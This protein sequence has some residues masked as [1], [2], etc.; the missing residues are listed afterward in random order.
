MGRHRDPHQ[1]GCSWPRQRAPASQS[2]DR[3]QT[4]FEA[5]PELR[6]VKVSADQNQ[7]VL[8]APDPLALVEG[9]P[10][11]DKVKY[12]SRITLGDPQNTFAAKDPD[13]TVLI[14]ERLKLVHCQRLIGGERDRAEPVSG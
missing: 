1:P 12:I 6:A 13:R 8:F 5:T 2:R 10:L 4:R 3:R 7:P 11:A 9:K 14:E